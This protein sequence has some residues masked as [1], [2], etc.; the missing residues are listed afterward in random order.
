[1]GTHD[2]QTDLRK[3]WA[4]INDSCKRDTLQKLAEMRGRRGRTVQ[5]VRIE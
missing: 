1:M 3:E 2:R 5:K 4:R